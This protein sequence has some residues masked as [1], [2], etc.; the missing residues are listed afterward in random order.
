MLQETGVVAPAVVGE[1]YPGVCPRVEAGEGRLALQAG[2]QLGIFTTFLQNKF[3]KIQYDTLFYIWVFLNGTTGEFSTHFQ[4]ENALSLAP[5][6]ILV[7]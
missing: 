6:I 7:I 1:D 5:H 3:Y 2:S 4:L